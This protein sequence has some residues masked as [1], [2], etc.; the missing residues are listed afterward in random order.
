M[1]STYMLCVMSMQ[2]MLT[3]DVDSKQ[4]S[5]INSFGEQNLRYITFIITGKEQHQAPSYF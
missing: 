2:L 4:C 5:Q 3:K 1:Q